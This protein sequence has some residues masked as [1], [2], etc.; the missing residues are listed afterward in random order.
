MKN[1]L[2]ISIVALMAVTNIHAASEGDIN[3]TLNV[4]GGAATE[5]VEAIFTPAGGG[6][7]EAVTLET[8]EAAGSRTLNHIIG[9]L[10]LSGTNVDPNTTCFINFSSANPANGSQF[11]LV[12]S[13]N[14]QNFITYY[15]QYQYTKNKSSSIST[16]YTYA[17][18]TDPNNPLRVDSVSNG[19]NGNNMCDIDVT[20]LRIRSNLELNG[21]NGNYQDVLTYTMVVI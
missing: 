6:A 14:D 21:K 8:I 15:L 5:E 3:L 1:K 16:G 20:D 2:L 18:T 19:G 13:N 10:S 17:N 11:T 9:N 4:G 12:D 7:G